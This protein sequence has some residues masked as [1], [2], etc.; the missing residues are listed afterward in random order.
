MGT[1][2]NGDL[3]WSIESPL[4]FSD[5]E[6]QTWSVESLIVFSNSKLG[7]SNIVCPATTNSEPV[8]YDT[9]DMA[10]TEDHTTPVDDDDDDN[11]NDDDDDDDDDDDQIDIPGIGRDVTM[12]GGYYWLRKLYENQDKVV[13]SMLELLVEMREQLEEEKKGNGIYI[14]ENKIPIY[15]LVDCDP[16]GFMIAQ[17]VKHS[18][19]EMKRR[20]IM[21]LGAKQ[22]KLIGLLP[23]DLT[24]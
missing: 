5:D 8:D 17:V 23:A 7:T 15:I 10:Q 19:K 2:T 20:G 11:D 21:G 9:Q 24:K 13:K 1:P 4:V 12:R 14:T 16:A 18:I 3:P 6:L 22:A